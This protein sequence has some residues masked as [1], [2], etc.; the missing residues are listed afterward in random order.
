[1]LVGDAIDLL[2]I[3]DG[4][5]DAQNAIEGACGE[6]EAFSGPVQEALAARVERADSSQCL[7]RQT[8]IHWRA[9]SASA[10]V[11]TRARK[12]DARSDRRSRLTFV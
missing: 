11:L 1:V 2:E 10:G 8:A 6:T 4:A 12:L 9:D 7:R 5:S 3:R